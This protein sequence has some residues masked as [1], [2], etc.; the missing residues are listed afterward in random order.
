MSIHLI[1]IAILAIYSASLWISSKNNLPV[2]HIYTMIE[3]STIM[4][5]YQIVFKNAINKVWFIAL[6]SAF[7]VFCVVNA[8]FIQKWHIFNTYPRT[9]ESIIIISTSL[10]YYYKI[11]KQTLYIQIEKS[12]TFWINTGFFIYFSGSFLLFMLSNYILPLSLKFNMIVWQLHAFLS[13]VLY[14]LIFIGLW[15]RRKA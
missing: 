4:L 7:L 14:C 12:A 5:F 13:C 1:L 15:Q 10:F 8:F 9:L 6:I 2:L 3:F 11:T